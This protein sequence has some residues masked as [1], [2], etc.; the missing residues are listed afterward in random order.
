VNVRAPALLIALGCVWGA[1]F[2]F[3]KVTVDQITPLEL[4]TGRLFFGALAVVPLVLYRRVPFVREPSMIG[5]LAVLAVLSNVA[6]FAL[7]AWAEVHI[8]TGVA[9]VLNATTPMF[10]A[11]FAAAALAEERFTPGRALGLAMALAG[12]VVLGGRDLLDITESDVLAQLAVVGASACYGAGAVYAR[13]LLRSGDPLGLSAVQL[14]L[15]S[16]AAFALALAVDGAP[17]YSLNAKGWLALLALGVLG[18]G[19]AFVVYLWLIDA[20]G[21]VRASLV[22][23][24]IPVV[25][26][27]LGWAVLDESIGVNTA[28]GAALI[29]GGVASVLQGQAPSTQRAAPAAIS[30]AD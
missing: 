22:A 2:L 10:T 24:I 27:L 29:I 15:G 19:F 17:D 9:S 13:T 26:L 8:E 5:K 18:S 23:Y 20:M 1:S 6:P 11:I 21:S 7:I 30:T 12:V 3:I 16:A 4:V 14:V 28:V 25:G